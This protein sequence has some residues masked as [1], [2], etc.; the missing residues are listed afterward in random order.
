MNELDLLKTHWQKDQ[1]YIKFKKEDILGMLHKSSSSIVKWIF[2]ICCLELL[3]G[4]LLNVAFP[5]KYN[6]NIYFKIKQVLIDIIGYSIPIYFIYKFFTLFRKIKSINN[7]KLLLENIAAV[8][9]N[10]ELYISYNLLFY[11]FLMIIQSI[12]KLVGSNGKYFGDDFLTHGW[13]YLGILIFGLLTAIIFTSLTI[14]L[15]RFI[16]KLYYKIIYGFLLK[17]LNKNYEELV[18]IEAG[19]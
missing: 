14:L 19:E 2:I 8:R 11:T 17:K 16:F 12:E 13:T 15:A 1:D 9:N 3:L 6:P 7:T 4:I 10:A 18:A 5:T